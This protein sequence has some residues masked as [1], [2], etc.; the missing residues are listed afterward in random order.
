[1]ETLRERTGRKRRHEHRHW[2]SPHRPCTRDIRKK[3]VFD[4]VRKT[5][6]ALCCLTLIIIAALPCLSAGFT[7]TSQD[8]SSLVRVDTR[9]ISQVTSSDSAFKARPSPGTP[10]LTL[11]SS[12]ITFSPSSPSEG[13][14]VTITATIHNIGATS[15]SS[16]IVGFYKGS[17]TGGLI[18]TDTIRRINAGKSDVAS[19]DWIA[20]PG[21]DLWVVVDPSN[22]INEGDGEGNNEASALNPVVP[23]EPYADFTA[24]VTS[25]DEPVTVRFTDQSDGLTIKSWSWDFGD[26]CISTEQNPV[27]MYT[28]NDTYTVSL[29]VTGTNNGEPTERSMIKHDYIVVLDT[30][31]I[32]DFTA[33]P[34][35]GEAPLSVS[36][37]DFSTSNDGIIS[38]QWDFGDGATSTDPNPSH[39]YSDDGTYTVILTVREAD[40]DTDTEA[41]GGYI[42]V[43]S[44]VIDYELFIEIDYL[45]SHKPTEEILAYIEAY[46]LS[47]NPSGDM[48]HVTFFVTNVTEEVLALGTV[49]YEDGIRNVEFWAIQNATNDLGDDTY[50]G[51]DPVFGTSGV[52]SSKWKWVLFGTSV[53]GEPYVVGYC[54]V[55][56]QRL[57]RFQWDAL[58]G[59]YMYIADEVADNWAL[60][61]T[62]WPADFDD[63]MKMVG[64]EACVLMHELGH[65][66][67]IELF[68]RRGREAY[69]ENAECVMSYLSVSNADNYGSWFYCAD[70]WAT[71][72]LEYY[73]NGEHFAG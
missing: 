66:I 36:F 12:A 11:T 16:V 40:D 34:T 17:P 19:V 44:P 50:P 52:V 23:T 2:L 42:T 4:K 5:I 54:H 20:E 31:P 43:G 6:F 10:D 70:H 15:A 57:S 68:D 13:D 32:A 53:E 35:S 59:N 45:G 1:M 39:I 48:I 9:W 56:R 65:S 58:A 18:D 3:W 51:E 41:K 73:G 64:A 61:K 14:T 72:H 49:N 22:A 7:L 62:G 26:S 71:R 24:D 29:T 69:C 46:Y 8:E 55:M 60:A 25:G 28:Q 30:P 27:H 67:G 33:T 21:Y 63:E 47:V 37:T 38:W